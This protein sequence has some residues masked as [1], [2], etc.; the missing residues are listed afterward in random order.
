MGEAE[1]QRVLELFKENSVEYKLFEHAP[2]YTSEEASR[3]RNVELKSGVKAMLVLV[4]PKT[5][6]EK[7]KRFFVLC[8]MAA[9]RRI[10]FRKLEEI[11]MAKRARFGTRDE[12]LSATGCE[13]GSVHPLG[14]L[15]QGVEK[16]F[17]DESVLENELVN[18]NIGL[19][20]QSVQ[21]KSKDLL[22]VLNPSYTGSFTKY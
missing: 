19:L 20:T 10:D 5:D 17:L 21:I 14:R 2:V 4:T 9:D 18:F 13:P 1:A 11:T 16:T 6:D 22:R 8:D 15:F 7:P 12:V 3:V